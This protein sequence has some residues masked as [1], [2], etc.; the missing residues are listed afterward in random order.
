[1]RME[2]SGVAEDNLEAVWVEPIDYQQ[3]LRQSVLEL[4]RRAMNVSVYNLPHCLLPSDLWRFARNSISGW[5]RAYLPQC[6]QCCKKDKCAGVFETSVRQSNSI[7][8]IFD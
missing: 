8:P 1:M 3:H 7:C 6:G 4:H 5:K 2:T